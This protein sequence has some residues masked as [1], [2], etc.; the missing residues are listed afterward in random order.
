MKG[1]FELKLL[2]INNLKMKNKRHSYNNINNNNHNNKNN[3]NPFWL[4]RDK[5]KR[6][7]L[8]KVALI[9]KRS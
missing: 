2:I 3:N 9:N 8:I 1:N 5:F 6:K 4:N 7:R